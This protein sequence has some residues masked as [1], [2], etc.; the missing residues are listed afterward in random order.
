MG[1]KLAG[2]KGVGGLQIIRV[3]D[4]RHSAGGLEEGKE[5]RKGEQIMFKDQLQQQLA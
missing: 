1:R 3:R 4:S 5:E 2:G